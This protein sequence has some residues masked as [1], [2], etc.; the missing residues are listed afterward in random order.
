[1][2]WT[3]QFWKGA[4]ERLLKTFVQSTVAA[5]LVAVGSAT[6]AWDVQWLDSGYDALGIGLMAAFLSLATSIGNADFTS[7]ESDAKHVL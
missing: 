4:G 7:G 5:L 1:M 2:I 6:S 3:K